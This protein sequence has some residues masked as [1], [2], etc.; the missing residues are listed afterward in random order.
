MRISGSRLLVFAS[1]VLF[2]VALTLDGASLSAQN[3][4]FKL[5]LHADSHGSAAEVGLPVYPGATLDKDTD[6][7]SAADLGFTFGETR[8]R[9]II[10]RY[11]TKDSPDSVLNFYRKPL[12]QYGDVL[13]C[14]QDKPVGKQTATK[15]GLTCSNDKESHVT[16]SDHTD[17]PGRHEIRAGS[18]HRYRIVAFEDSDHGLTRF[19]LVYIET[20]KDSDKA[21][22]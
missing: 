3:S 21:E 22:K 17:L 14:S 15:S 20:P 9:L 8:F 18:P 4:D 13:E 2:A 10:A 19:A 5:E 12:S 1:S 11:A 6:N 7:S 16:V